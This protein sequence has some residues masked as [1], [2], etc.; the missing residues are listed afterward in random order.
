M[1]RNGALY[2]L[3]PWAPWVE[4]LLTYTLREFPPGGGRPTFTEELLYGAEPDGSSGIFPAG[5][6]Q[7]VVK[8]LKAKG[9]TY[10]IEDY[11]DLKTLMPQPDFSRVVALRPGQDRMLAAV[12][13]SDGGQL[14]GATGLGKSVLIVQICKMYPTL[15]IVVTT[16]RASVVKT[17]HERLAAEVAYTE[18]GMIG[19]G[20]NE[21][22]RRI[23]VCT[24]KSIMKAPLKECDL[25]LFD[26][27]HGVGRNLIGSQLAY[28]QRAR[29]F[30]FTA[31]PV[32]R[33]D[34]AELAIEA[35]FGPVLVDIS[36]SKAVA[37]G[38]VVPIEVHWYPVRSAAN[39]NEQAATVTRKRYG[40][41]RNTARNETIAAVAK[42]FPDDEQVLIMVETL[43]HAIYLHKLLPDFQV[44]HCGTNK[45][46][47]IGGEWVD[48][49]AMDDAKLARVRRDFEKG[50]LKKAI[51]TGVWGE[52]VDFANLA[53]LIR[54]DAM[55]SPI[56]GNQIPGRLSRLAEGKDKG[57]LIDFGDEFSRWSAA[58][59]SSRRKIYEDT[60]WRVVNK[61]LI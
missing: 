5:L 60:G 50:R 10:K 7:R 35:L 36:Y 59:A 8:A 44:V 4:P 19:G 1:K 20:K 30:G 38:L 45:K 37:D 15:K 57:L 39:F 58:R 29:K 24:T 25:L 52:G 42:G 61:E 55:T 26:E 2:S 31:T 32:G 46:K 3:S 21:T 27:V 47:R 17:L 14:V 13:S 28:V 6:F 49:F 53:V 43:E 56:K 22:G 16:P 33:G 48:K 9:H 34:N 12:A 11:R 54:A 51:S 18:V 23:T 40:Y 41:W